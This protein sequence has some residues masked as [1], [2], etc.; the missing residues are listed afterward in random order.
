M[1]TWRSPAWRS[2]GGQRRRRTAP[3]SKPVIFEG[4][5]GRVPLTSWTLRRDPSNHGRSRGWSRGGFPG[6]TVSVP[7]VVNPTPYTGKAG[8]VNYE[9]SIAW[10][11][12]SFQAATAGV[13][14]LSFQSA[15]YLATVWVDGQRLGSHHGSY[16]PFEERARLAAGTH[17]VVVR[18]DWQDPAQQAREGFHRTWFNWGGLDGEVDVR[19]DRRKRIVRADRA[20][21]AQRAG[22]SAIGAVADRPAHP[23]W[24]AGDRRT[25]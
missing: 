8:G 7:N 2:G 22:R 23:A 12:T 24:W 9:G 10:Y 25:T 16:L 3:A 13:Y 17:T 14:A 1:R 20:D 19:A 4:P 5:G 6:A 21:H 18:T 11:R 15:N